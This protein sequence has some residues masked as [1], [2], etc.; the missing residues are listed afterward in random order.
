MKVRQWSSIINIV[1]N[2]GISSHEMKTTCDIKDRFHHNHFPLQ[3]LKAKTQWKNYSNQI[4]IVWIN[5]L[6]KD[7]APFLVYLV[8]DQSKRSNQIKEHQHVKIEIQWKFKGVVAIRSNHHYKIVVK[9]N[10]P[11]EQLK[12][13]DSRRMCL[14]AYILHSKSFK[15]QI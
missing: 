13:Q 4:R 8:E 3:I 12:S 9:S 14:P 6:K 1:Q 15:K 11:W 10:N 5:P 7:P 2:Q